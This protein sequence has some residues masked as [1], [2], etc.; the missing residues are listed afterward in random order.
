[1]SPNAPAIV[2]DPAL[3]S[4]ADGGRP[5]PD[6]PRSAPQRRAD[7]LVELCRRHLDRGDS[8]ISGGVRPH[9]TV[10][11]DL[12]AL[13]GRA[14]RTCEIDPTGAVTPQAARRLACD[15]GVSRIITAGES[16]P[17][18]V[19]R[20]TRTIPAAVRR[21][22]ESRDRGCHHPG[23]G[24]PPQW[25]DAHHIRHWA[26][27]GPTSLDNLRLLCRRHHRTAHEGDLPR[28]E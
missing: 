1:M 22:L 4:L 18:D 19:G 23:C 24:M 7:A 13:E 2:A 10:T 6:D 9:L 17:L 11:I 12:E 25:C 16:R 14:G 5:D 21:A 27:G 3:R 20:T 26:D 8:P 15:A 28:R